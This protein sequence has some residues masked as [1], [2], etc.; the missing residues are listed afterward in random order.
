M[1]LVTFLL[2]AVTTLFGALV[3]ASPIDIDMKLVPRSATI[4]AM[5]V[6]QESGYTPAAMFASAAYCPASQTATWSCGGESSLTFM[7]SLFYN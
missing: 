6:A 3:H 2:S 7:Q 1:A 4:H 5:T